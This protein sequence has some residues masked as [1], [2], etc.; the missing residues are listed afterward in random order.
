MWRRNLLRLQ[1]TT[2][3]VRHNYA[4]MHKFFISYAGYCTDVQGYET[5][6]LFAQNLVKCVATLPCDSSLITISVSD[7]C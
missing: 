1:V 2:V 5:V 7:Y 3:T 4:H 6:N